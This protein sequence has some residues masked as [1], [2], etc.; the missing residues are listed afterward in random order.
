[1]EVLSVNGL[2]FASKLYQN[3]CLILGIANTFTSAYHLQKDGQVERFNHYIAAMLRCYVFYYAETWDEHLEPL[4]HVYNLRVHRAVGTRPF[5]LVISRPHPEFTLHYDDDEAPVPT[6][7]HC[8]DFANQLRKVITKARIS[9]DKVQ[10]R[11]ES[12][13]D[14]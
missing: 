9:L 11:Y 13:F 7:K 6:G 10:N 12:D 1:M 3:A 5:D 14:K 8:T 4:M 2:Q